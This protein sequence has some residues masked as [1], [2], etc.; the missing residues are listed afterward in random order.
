MENINVSEE[1]LISTERK[2]RDG[3]RHL[4]QTIEKLDKNVQNIVTHWNDSKYR[5]LVDIVQICKGELNDILLILEEGQL[6]ILTLIQNIREYNAV[7]LN[8]RSSYN[9]TSQIL[10][11]LDRNDVELVNDENIPHWRNISKAH[12]YIED[13]KDTNPNYNKGKKWKINCQRCVPT[14]E[15]R[16][17]GYNVTALPYGIFT[18]SYIS[19]HPFTVWTD[20]VVNNCNR[21]GL[22][23]IKNAMIEWGDGAKAQIV[24][25]WRNTNVGHTFIAEQIGGTT[26]FIDPQTNENNVEYYFNSVSFGETQFCRIDNLEVSNRIVEC[27]EEVQD[28]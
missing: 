16:R 13:L 12:D 27:C 25:T 5:D 24:V 9:S 26:I 8:T 22:S 10:Q 28:G 6:N 14:Y 1:V 4:K 11:T 15:M 17:R 18:S 2:I 7:N 3:I 23:D 21:S 19:Y 20:A